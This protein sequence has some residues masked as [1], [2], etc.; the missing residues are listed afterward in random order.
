MLGNKSV[1][2]TKIPEETLSWAAKLL[3]KSSSK[4]FFSEKCIS[5]NRKLTFHS[6]S[7]CKAYSHNRTL[8]QHFFSFH[9]SRIM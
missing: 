9:K 8:Y 1:K 2:L 7:K 3:L 6:T 5:E 4:P